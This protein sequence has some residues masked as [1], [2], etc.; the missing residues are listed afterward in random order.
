MVRKQYSFDQI[1]KMKLLLTVL[2]VCITSAGFSQ[3]DD[4]RKKQFNLDDGV[5]IKGYDPVAY[6][7][8]G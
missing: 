2:F 6:F 5:A 7:T 1:L 3:A 4:F 8:I